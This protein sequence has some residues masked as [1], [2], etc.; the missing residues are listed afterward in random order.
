LTADLDTLWAVMIGALLATAGGFGATQLE[1]FLRRRERERSAALLFGEILSV[2]K[3]VV[4]FADDARAVGDPYGPLTMRLLRA[5][6]RETE[7]YDR[8]RESLYDL[9]DAG[10]RAQIHSLVVRVSLGLEGVFDA[11]Q[12]IAE[13]DGALKALEPED[14]AA[15]ELVARRE[16]LSESRDAA[17]EFAVES[18]GEVEA[19]VAVLRPLAKQSFDTYATIIRG[20]GP[21]GGPQAA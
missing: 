21:G 6:Q 20:A 5:A 12:E 2:L 1:G 17:F 10:A 8:N 18:L 11:G 13:A 7:A 9:R 16:A 15:A 14:S 4:G 3:L 19:I